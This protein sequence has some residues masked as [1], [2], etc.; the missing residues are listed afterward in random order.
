MAR[1]W[2][3]LAVWCG[4]PRSRSR[5]PKQFLS[6]AGESSLLQQ[7][8]DRL[9][10]AFRPEDIFV[11]TTEELAGETRRMLP[12]LPASVDGTGH[13]DMW[14]YLVD[15]DTVIISEFIAGSNA[16]AIS[17]TNNAVPYMQALGFE[18]FRTPAWNSGFTHFTYALI[19]A[20][21]GGHAR[22]GAAPFL[23]PV[24]RTGVWRL[25]RVSGAVGTESLG[26]TGL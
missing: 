19:G 3:P 26:P 9:E 11:L 16:T 15:E 14:M 7:T 25:Y 10:G 18:V 1:A 20:P 13:V 4:W 2:S 8:V 21:A 23:T 24:T 12:Q 6:M 17:V 5:R 22:L